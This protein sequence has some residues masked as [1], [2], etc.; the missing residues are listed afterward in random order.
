ML[1]HIVLAAAALV[2][3]AGHDAVP[4]RA[5]PIAVAPSGEAS[6][7][8]PGAPPGEASGQPTLPDPLD[9]EFIPRNRPI[10]DCI[11]ALPKPGCGSE[12]RGGWRQGLVLLAIVLGLAFIAWRVV[13][14]ARRARDASGSAA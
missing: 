6:G 13:R 4:P 11:S 9:N 8:P 1:A 2:A 12:A 14:S 5:A 7:Q 10:G 3:G